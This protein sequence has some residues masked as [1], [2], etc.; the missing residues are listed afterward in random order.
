MDPV[1]AKHPPEMS[2]QEEDPEL[3][4]FPAAQ[5]LQLVKPAAELYAPAGHEV[6]LLIDVED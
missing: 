4:Y 5:V 2:K 1:R 6:Q 3:L